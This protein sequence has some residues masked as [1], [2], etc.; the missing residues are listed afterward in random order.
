MATTY[1]V[2]LTGIGVGDKV[3]T[4]ALA[5]GVTTGSTAIDEVLA[6]SEYQVVTVEGQT[7]TIPGSP[8]VGVMVPVLDGQSPGR[9]GQLPAARLLRPVRHRFD[10]GE[11]ADI[12]PRGGRQRNH[13]AAR[14]RHGGYDDD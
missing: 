13:A 12:Q 7:D 1:R 4:V 6:L 5:G 2:T 9:H 14:G 8:P 11:P 3:Y 10:Q